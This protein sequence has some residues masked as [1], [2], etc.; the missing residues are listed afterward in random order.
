MGH[1]E[2]EN[3]QNRKYISINE[4]IK[5]LAKLASADGVLT[6]N[7]LAILKEF[8]EKYNIGFPLIYK[9]AKGYEERVN[10]PEVEY[11][12]DTE[13]KGKLFEKFVVDLIPINLGFKLLSWRGDKVHANIYSQD[14]LYPDLWIQ[15]P[16]SSG[17]IDYYIECKYR[18]WWDDNEVIFEDWQIKRYKDFQ[19][20]KKRKILIALGVGGSPEKPET[21]MI[22]PLDSINDGR[23]KK[24]DTQF[25]VTPTSDN[26]VKYMNNYFYTVF[27][28]TKEK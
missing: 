16:K 27:S 4:A 3:S 15:H 28:K 22:V 5:W 23:I 25:V 6:P 24:I 17:S 8:G 12:T 10:L 7:E 14:S 18:S 1:R 9:K 21:L 26:F 11:F 2:K 20:E 19:R 13:M